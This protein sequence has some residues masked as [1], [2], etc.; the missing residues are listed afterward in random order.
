[1]A[2]LSECLARRDWAAKQLDGLTK[3][4][5]DYEASEPY[6]LVDQLDPSRWFSTVVVKPTPV[7]MEISFMAGD[8]VHNLRS[9]LDHLVWQLTLA[10]DNPKP[11]FPL[12]SGSSWRDV[13]FPLQEDAS[14]PWPPKGLWGVSEEFR[15]FIWDIQ[16]YI[17]AENPRNATVWKLHE[18]SN[19]DKHRVPLLAVLSLYETRN[20][21]ITIPTGRKSVNTSATDIARVPLMLEKETPIV[22]VQ[23]DTP[24][25]I[26]T[27]VEYGVGICVAF[28]DDLGIGPGM[29]VVDMLDMMLAMVSYIVDKAS[30]IGSPHA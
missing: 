17:A 18:L 13:F 6:E 27:I 21:T 29:P 14:K 23:Y 3:A 16:P 19:A 15:T 25:L 12:P 4:I 2:D 1:M 26:P 9:T 20:V 7:P 22:R 28:H 10:N 8:V 30:V 11:V 24:P 5:R